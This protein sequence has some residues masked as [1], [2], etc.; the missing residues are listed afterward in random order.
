MQLSEILLKLGP[1]E[2]ASLAG[3]IS[4]GKLRTYQLFDSFKA[5]A[6]V[7]KL[8]A[9]SL[10]KAIPRLYERLPDKDEDLAR[11]LAQAILMA[12][13]DLVIAVLDFLGIPHQDGFFDKQLDASPYLTS[14]WQQRVYEKFKDA[15]PPSALLFYINHLAWELDKKSEYFQPE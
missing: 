4:I 6:R 2:F 3:K 8:N 13:L 5:H 9:E 11:D 14:G 7:H 1:Q 10:R 15:F 12:H